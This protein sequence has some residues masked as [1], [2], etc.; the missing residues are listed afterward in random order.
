MGK[1]SISL[2]TRFMISSICCGDKLVA[3]SLITC[4][5][6]NPTESTRTSTVSQFRN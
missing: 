5:T 6:N 1:M 2:V 3:V 4:R